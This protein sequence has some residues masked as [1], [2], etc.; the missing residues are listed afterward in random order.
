MPVIVDKLKLPKGRDRRVKLSPGKK[1]EI[2]AE[3]KPFIV[4]LNFLAKKH[5]VSKKTIF[6]I[7]HPEVQKK[8]AED[9]R[10]RRKDGRYYNR[11]TH[12]KA[13][14]SLRTYKRKIFNIPK[15]WSHDTYNK[16]IHRIT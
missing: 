9:Y 11:E 10:E 2:K 16:Q 7:I 1:A 3:Y 4:S 5:G 12:T 14:K 6:Y 8:D 15:D 13:I